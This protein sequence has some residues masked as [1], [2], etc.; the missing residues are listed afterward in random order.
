VKDA[1][2]AFLAASL[3]LHLAVA[4]GAWIESIRTRAH[5]PEPTPPPALAGDSFVAPSLEDVGEE[6]PR[7][8]PNATAGDITVSPSTP[9]EARPDQ[10][11][12]GAERATPL[13]R[14]GAN[15]PPKKRGAAPTAAS[16]D[17][18]NAGAGATEPSLYGAV[19]ERTAVDLPR[20]FTRMFSNASS[21]DP[22]WDRA[23]LGPVA[24]VTVTITLDDSGHIADVQTAGGGPLASSVA[25]TMSLMRARPFTARAK[26]TR[27]HISARISADSTDYFMV[28]Q[29]EA[30]SYFRLASGRRVEAKITSR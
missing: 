27:L 18:P 6:A 7:E 12:D 4:G 24:D 16:A 19:G 3:A 22:A 14:T 8:E 2:P 11:D 25:R 5:A 28:G 10:A 20:G 15:R 21:A 17:A 1:L 9:A 23:P 13:R 29:E 26:V 30:T